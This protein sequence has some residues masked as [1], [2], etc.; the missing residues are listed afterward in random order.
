MRFAVLREK[1]YESFYGLKENPFRM[2]PDPKFLYLGT[3]HKEALAQLWYGVREN[4]GFIVMTGEVGTGKTT[5]LHSLLARLNGNGTIK[6]ALLF[7][8]KLDV[9]DFLQYILRDFGVKVHKGSKGDHLQALHKYL[10]ETYENNGKVVLIV[11]EAQ[12]LDPELLEELRLLSNLE[13]SKSKLLQIILVGQPELNTTLSR[14]E[15]RQLKQRINL[16]YHI[17]PLSFE[18]T[19]GYIERRLIIAGAKEPLFTKRALKEIY[20]K[21]GGIPRLINILCDNALLSGYAADLKTVDEALVK[22]VAKDLRLE[23]RSFHDWIWIIVGIAMAVGILTLFY[24]G[25]AGLL[26]SFFR[27]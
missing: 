7:N 19:K 17:P 8:P 2:T 1:M 9:N 11:D 14:P 5:L 12:T 20:Q 27:W 26:W 10:L 6:T 23:K 3:D 4:K 16:R 24:V 21:S 15:F 25:K 22:E 18:E 13:T